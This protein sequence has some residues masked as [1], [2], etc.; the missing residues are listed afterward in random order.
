MRLV[1]GTR[2][3]AATAQATLAW[4]VTHRQ[5]LA[6]VEEKRPV[7]PVALASAISEVQDLI[8]RICEL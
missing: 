2:L 6:A 3:I 4:S 1:T 7:N 5:R 8:G